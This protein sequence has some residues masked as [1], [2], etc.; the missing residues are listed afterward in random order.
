MN[1]DCKPLSGGVDVR[2]REIP[3]SQP[4]AIGTPAPEFAPI[5]RAQ[6]A[7]WL[8]R[9]YQ[10][11]AHWPDPDYFDDLRER[12]TGAVVVRGGRV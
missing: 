4:P 5:R 10:R 1:A 6:A 2:A 12:Y 9:N 8:A 11:P 7:C 3:Y